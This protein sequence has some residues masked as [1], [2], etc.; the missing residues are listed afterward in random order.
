MNP[1][2][3]CN[4]YRKA[5]GA[6]D[7][8]APLD[9]VPLLNDPL[10]A[11]LP[12]EEDVGETVPVSY[13]EGRDFLIPSTGAD[14]ESL[15]VLER[16]GVHPRFSCLAMEDSAVIKMVEQGMGCSI[17]SELVLKIR[18]SLDMEP[19]IRR[20]EETRKTCSWRLRRSGRACRRCWP[21]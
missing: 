1:R 11:V 2:G 4:G 17:L 12:L 21:R 6:Q 9:F 19:P 20:L 14:L 15:R 8:T 7:R 16:G 10:Y 3:E 13:F 18:S 5:E